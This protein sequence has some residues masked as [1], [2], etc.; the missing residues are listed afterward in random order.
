LH[1]VSQSFSWIDIPLVFL[2]LAI[3]ILLASDNAAALAMIV[4]KLPVELKKKALFTGLISAFFFRAIGIIF[5]AFLIYLFWMQIIGGI[6]LIYLAW[7]F[8]FISKKEISPFCPT[9]YWKAVLYIEIIDVLFAIDSILGAFALASLYY[10]F[11][12]ISSKIWVIYMGGILGV[13]AIRLVT[14]KFIVL[15]NKH[16]QIERIAFLVIGWMG[17]KLLAEGSLFFIAS[18]TVRHAFDLF[19]WIGTLFIVLI[20]IFS[21]RLKAAN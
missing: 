11:E 19:F 5:T 7:H 8:F 6:Y 18:E 17:I 12:V 13:V 16:K 20:G 10:P 2:I 15:L 4:K 21:K 1:F 9:Q 3:E 14:G